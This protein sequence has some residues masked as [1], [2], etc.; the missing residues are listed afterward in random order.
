MDTP[1]PKWTFEFQF[2][3]CMYTRILHTHTSRAHPR[4]LPHQV[5]PKRDRCRPVPIQQRIVRF[6]FS[7]RRGGRGGGCSGGE[8][9]VEAGVVEEDEGRALLLLIYVGCVGGVYV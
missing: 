4:P 9:R 7:I 3:L 2:Y 5:L 8:R 1:N 6:R